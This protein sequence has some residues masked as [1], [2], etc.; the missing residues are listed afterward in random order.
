MNAKHCLSNEMAWL[1]PKEFLFAHVQVVN[2]YQY[3]SSRFRVQS[4]PFFA[5]A[6][7]HVDGILTVWFATGSVQRSSLKCP[8]RYRSN[9]LWSNWSAYWLLPVACRS[10]C[11]NL[12][13]LLYKQL[14]QQL[15]SG[16]IAR[17]HHN[18]VTGK[19]CVNFKVFDIFD[20]E[21]IP[22]RRSSK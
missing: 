14:K 5:F 4:M 18:F 12:H 22:V 15:I 20:P 21:P 16:G 19:R 3:I 11:Q 10:Q 2:E 7:L 6:D 8:P 13:A 9:C 17:W 1:S